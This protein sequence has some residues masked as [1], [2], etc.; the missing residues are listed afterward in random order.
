MNRDNRRLRLVFALLVVTSL[1]LLTADLR[2]GKGGAFGAVRGAVAS[3]L[4]PVQDGVSSGFAPI[5]RSVTAAIHSGRDQRR[6]DALQKQVIELQQA[7]DRDAELK[8]DEAEL[9]KLGVL[10]YLTDTKGV[11]A[12][13]ISR[14]DAVD[15]F[16]QT[17]QLDVGSIDHVKLGLPVVAS[18]GLVGLVV[19]VSGKTCVIRLIDDLGNVVFVDT[20]SGNHLS[21]YVTGQ[22]PNEKL[23]YTQQFP[24]GQLRSG[25]GL[26]TAQGSAYNEGIPVGILGSSSETAGGT[27]QTAEVTPSAQVDTADVVEVLLEQSIN[28]PRAPITPQSPSPSRATTP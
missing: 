14:G 20:V 28:A 16:E 5:R 18:D 19:R 25:T 6:I 26:V 11:F 21:A 7:Q 27:E 8:R 23:T 9:Q 4:G 10:N 24:A 13:V 12:K 17:A 2:G 1:T 15:G 3:V 22:G